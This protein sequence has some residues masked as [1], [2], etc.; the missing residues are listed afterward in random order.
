MLEEPSKSKKQYDCLLNSLSWYENVCGV[1]GLQGILTPDAWFL[2]EPAPPYYSNVVSLS[3]GGI[4][5]QRAAISD[6]ASHLTG[7]FS[8]KD[9]FATLDL[10]GIGFRELFSAHWLWQDPSTTAVS[11]GNLNLWSKISTEPELKE[12]ESA[13]SSSGSPTND[14]VFKPA[15]LNAESVCFFAARKSGRV[16]AGCIANRSPN[17]VVGFSNFFAPECERDMYEGQAVACAS[18]FAAGEPLVGYEHGSD[19][20]RLESLGFSRVGSLRVWLRHC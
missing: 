3:V 8:V 19:L 14:S 17:G 7:G 4:A 9:S 12:W 13:W 6:V 18:N 1:W 11:T 5:A 20:Q 10:S 2:R 16:V 15:L